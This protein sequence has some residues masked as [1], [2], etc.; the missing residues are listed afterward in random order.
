[1]YL[2][3]ECA[4]VDAL[5]NVGHR[6]HSAT[7]TDVDP[8]LVTHDEQ[9]FSKEFADPMGNDA[10]S[11]HLSEA[12]PTCS[13]S[14]V[15]RLTGEC[16]H[17]SSAPGIHLIVYQVPQTLVV[18][19]SNKQQIA[20]LL[21]RVRVKHDLV[22]ELLIACLMELFGLLFDMEATEGSGVVREPSLDGS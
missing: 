1:M 12:K 18:N 4:L 5:G 10:I 15:S 11:L 9:S 16:H 3:A 14:A 20:K 2:L 13:A 6:H 7:S 21:T 19:R 8:E 17:W 22:S